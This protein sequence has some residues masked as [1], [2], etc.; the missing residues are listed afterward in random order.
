MQK[1][2]KATKLLQTI[3]HHLGKDT[4]TYRWAEHQLLSGC[5]P[6]DVIAVL[7]ASAGVTL[8]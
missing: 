4:E 8:N 2:E 6:D 7:Q 3:E 1:N 5:C